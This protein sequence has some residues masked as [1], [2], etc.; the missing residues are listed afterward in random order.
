MSVSLTPVGTLTATLSATGALHA[1]ISG[2]RSL[3][4]QLFFTE[5]SVLANTVFTYKGSVTDISSLPATAENG[6]AYYVESDTTYYAWM[7]ERW[8][9]I[10]AGTMTEDL[11]AAQIAELQGLVE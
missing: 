9:D 3:S 6:D 5:Q 11:T 2:N 4:A 1:V 7:G 10:G 8:Q